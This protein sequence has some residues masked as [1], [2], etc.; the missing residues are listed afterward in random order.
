MTLSPCLRNCRAIYDK[1]RHFSRGCKVVAPWL[2]CVSEIFRDT[3][4]DQPH[5][6]EFTKNSA[7]HLL[8]RQAQPWTRFLSHT[9]H[10]QA[11]VCVCLLKCWLSD[12]QEWTCS[13]LHY[14]MKASLCSWYFFPISGSQRKIRF[15][16][17]LKHFQYGSEVETNRLEKPAAPKF[18]DY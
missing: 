17:C 10:W 18:L 6:H 1:T 13:A 3:H 2:D 4:L 14:T 11:V 7:R 5:P 8:A 15:F 16:G 12:T 9:T